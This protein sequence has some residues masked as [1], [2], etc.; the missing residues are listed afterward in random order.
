MISLC[1]PHHLSQYFVEIPI[2]VNLILVTYNAWR[3]VKSM[4]PGNTGM[5]HPWQNESSFLN[6]MLGIRVRQRRISLHSCNL[7]P[8]LHALQKK[9]QFDWFKSYNDL[10]QL[11]YELVLEKQSRILMLGCGN[12]KL[13]EDV[14]FIGPA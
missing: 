12:S 9:D 3:C 7:I 2:T 6:V 13:S 1:H 5:L 14:C 11:L 4:A 8:Y 10:A